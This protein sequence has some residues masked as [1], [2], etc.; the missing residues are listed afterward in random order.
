M[1]RYEV[2]LAPAAQTQARKITDW[3][4]DNRQSI[5]D[6]FTEEMD[7]V[8]SPDASAAGAAPSVAFGASLQAPANRWPTTRKWS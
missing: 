5:P 8:P 6:L 3:W 7:A 2:V 1:K 4:R